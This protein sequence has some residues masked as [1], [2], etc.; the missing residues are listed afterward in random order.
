MGFEGFGVGDVELV[1]VVE[2][3]RRAEGETSELGAEV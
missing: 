1:V 2:E 3:A